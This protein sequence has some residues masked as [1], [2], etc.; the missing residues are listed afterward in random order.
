LT[1][2]AYW[3][4]QFESIGNW[5]AWLAEVDSVDE[6]SIIRRNILKGLPCGSD[7]LIQKLEKKIGQMLK[8]RLLGRSRKPVDS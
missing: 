1:T 4:K 7:R 8:Y 3:K 5:F 6:L 2:K